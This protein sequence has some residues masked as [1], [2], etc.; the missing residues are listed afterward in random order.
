MH[1]N[2][3]LLAEG[4]DKFMRT[5]RLSTLYSEKVH[6]YLTTNDDF[7]DWMSEQHGK[8][9]TVENN[10]AAL[11]KLSQRYTPEKLKQLF[12][13][14]TGKRQISKFMS[15]LSLGQLQTFVT[16]NRRHRSDIA[17]L[18]GEGIV[19]PI[20]DRVALH[21]QEGSTRLAE[22]ASAMDT[23]RSLQLPDMNMSE[24]PLTYF[25]GA[26]NNPSAC[27]LFEL[28]M[29][30]I[31][32]EVKNDPQAY[33]GSESLPELNFMMTRQASVL[34]YFMTA[35]AYSINHDCAAVTWDEPSRVLFDRFMDAGMSST[36]PATGFLTQRQNIKNSLG[37]MILNDAVPDVSLLPLEVI[38]DLRQRRASELAM[39]RAALASLSTK[40]DPSLQGDELKLA[41]R[42]VIASEVTPSLLNLKAALDAKNN[43]AIRKAINLTPAVAPALVSFGISAACGVPVDTS[44][45]IGAGIAVFNQVLD[46]TL[47]KHLEKSDIL[48]S[49]PWSIIYRLQ[50]Q[51]PR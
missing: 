51:S 6:C 50:D 26:R 13:T 36:G 10:V 24:L 37:S 35:V 14:P 41:I 15:A 4:N 42:D 29:H 22:L 30:V 21:L 12:Q 19:V 25:K 47:G 45:Q 31:A 33:E 32:A 7:L 28:G 43:E 46:F 5:L 40:I 16:F 9:P 39:F 8:L 11:T 3:L 48:R 27:F 34:L 38:L 20:L 1:D 44:V 2:V 49:S 23:L 18:S 17:D